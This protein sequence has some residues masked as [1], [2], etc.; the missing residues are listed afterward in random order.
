MSAEINRIGFIK[1]MYRTDTNLE[2]ATKTEDRIGISVTEGSTLEHL[3]QAYIANGGNPL[4]ISSTMYPQSS[5]VDVDENGDATVAEDYPNSGVVSPFSAD[6]NDPMVS[7]TN[8]GYGVYPGGMPKNHRYYPSRQGGQISNGAY[9]HASLV[10]TMHQIRSWANQDI[11]EIL[12]DLEFR[13][14]KQCDLREQLIRERDEVLVQAF[15]GFLDGVPDSDSD[16]FDTNMLMQ[17]LIQDL[18]DMVYEKMPD[19]T[20]VPRHRSDAYLLFTFPNIPGDFSIE[21]GM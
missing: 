4:E 9:D 15:G 16:R 14:I 19:G 3:L 12:S 10:K 5:E 17:N 7:A 20:L 11:K 1:V 13:I 21:L 18:S 2:G 6:P 8:T